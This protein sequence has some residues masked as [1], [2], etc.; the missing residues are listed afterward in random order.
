[1]NDLRV[2]SEKSER[3]DNKGKPFTDLYLCWTYEGKDYK[4]RIR[5]QFYK[6]LDKLCALCS[7]T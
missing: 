2:I 4:V 7:S 1:M 3:L 6:D 5:P